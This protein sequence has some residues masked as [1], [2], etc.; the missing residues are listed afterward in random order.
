M[1]KIFF[2]S[3]IALLTLS[4]CRKESTTLLKDQTSA[5]SESQTNVISSGAFP[6]NDHEIVYYDGQQFYNSCTNELITVSGNAQ[7]IFDGI[8]NGTKSTITV[9]WHIRGIKATGESGREYTI[10][11]GSTYQESS[12]SNGVFTTKFVR[13]VRWVTAGS[14]NNFIQKVTVY[15]KIDAEG[16]ITYLRDPVSENYCQ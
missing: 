7:F 10:N 12:F 8:Y 5:K 16:N 6:F 11:G 9:N 4:S 13:S 2:F 1:K 14:A 3:T 15:F